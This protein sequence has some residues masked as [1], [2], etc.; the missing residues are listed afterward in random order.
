M[1]DQKLLKVFLNHLYET[2]ALSVTPDDLNVA[3]EEVA[4]RFAIA[5]N[6]KYQTVVLNALKEDSNAEKQ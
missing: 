1:R 3:V 5:E 4:E 2:G 6:L